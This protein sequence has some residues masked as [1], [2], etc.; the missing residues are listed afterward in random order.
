MAA[1]FKVA[2]KW[3]FL[4]NITFC[5]YSQRKKMKKA[6]FTT[7]AGLSIILSGCGKFGK[8]KGLPNDGQLYGV[9]P[10]GR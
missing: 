4:I 6:F 7:V 8:S 1:V 5:P 9:A 10:S 3:V 2:R